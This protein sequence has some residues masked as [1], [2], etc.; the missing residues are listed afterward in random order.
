MASFAKTII[1]G[2]CG[3]DIELRYLPSGQAV[4]NVSVAT[5]EKRKENGEAQEITTWW[6]C[7]LWARHAEL[8][9]QYLQKGSQV[10]FEG[11]PCLREYTDRDGNKRQSL[12]L[13]VSDMQF[14]GSKSD[15]TEPTRGEVKTAFAGAKPAVEENDV[16][17]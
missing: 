12:E 13:T 2:Y 3:R 1:V 10:Y 8:A 7:T 6:K 11:R 14:L 15:A 9:N 5:T 16:P 17:F 4:A